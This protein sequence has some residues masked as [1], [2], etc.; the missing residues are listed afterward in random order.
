MTN[1]APDLLKVMPRISFGNKMRRGLWR[2]TWFVLCRFT[3]VPLHSWRSA[4]LRLFG[5]QIPGRAFP[6]PSARIWAPWNLEMGTDSCL[7][8]GVDC[9]N[10]APIRLGHGV[11]ISQRSYLCTASHDFDNPD[12]PLIAG[13][14]DIKSGVWVAAECFVGPGISIAE[15]AVVLARSVVVRDIESN[16]VVAGNPARIVRRRASDLVSRSK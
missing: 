10:V 8:A 15:N 14:I 7:A 4:V 2:M 12:F 5:A 3:P 11:T 9:Y 16:N 13:E 6:Y 1:A